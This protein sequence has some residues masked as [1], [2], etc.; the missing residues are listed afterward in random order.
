MLLV[1]VWS[2]IVL[3]VS[4]CVVL[5]LLV[6][7]IV[8]FCLLVSEV[9]FELKWLLLLVLRFWVF[10]IFVLGSVVVIVVVRVKGECFMFLG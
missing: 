4:F 2:V 1:R 9:I 10:V 6:M 3:V 8:S 7:W 5:L